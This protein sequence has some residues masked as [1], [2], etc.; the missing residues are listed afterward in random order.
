MVSKKLPNKIF[1]QMMLANL[2]P[3][4]SLRDLEGDVIFTSEIMK[5][6]RTEIKGTTFDLI[7]YVYFTDDD[8]KLTNEYTDELYDRIIKLLW[9]SDAHV[10]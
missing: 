6:L 10:K 4:S 8:F 2:L 7:Q 3:K 1:D 5:I 9:K